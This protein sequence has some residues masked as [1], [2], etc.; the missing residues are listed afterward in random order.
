MVTLQRS[1]KKVVSLGIF[2]S[3]F[4]YFFDASLFLLAFSA[5]ERYFFPISP[6]HEV[7]VKSVHKS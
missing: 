6:S 4:F 2:C 7:I 3:N 1:R 5:R